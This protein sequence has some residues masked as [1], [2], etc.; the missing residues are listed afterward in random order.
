[1]TPRTR[2][3]LLLVKRGL[4]ETRAG[5]QAA[6]AAGQVTVDGKVAAKPAAPT[7]VDAIINAAP[8]HPYVSRGGIK[9][10]FALDQSAI[11]VSGRTCI[12]VGASTGGFTQVLLERGAARVYAVDV[13]HGQLH[14]SLRQQAKVIS[15]EGSDIRTIAAEL[16][17]PRPDLVTIDVSFIALEQVLPAVF[18]IVA[19]PCDIVALIKPQFELTRRDLKK[20]IVRDPQRQAAACNKV[21]AFLKAAGCEVISIFRS[22][23]TGSDGNV[24]FFVIARLP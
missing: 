21:V 12:D 4:F 15:L 11:V 14:P 23:I 3:D 8:A 22:P 16:F 6:I 2:L 7:N 5:A 1:M 24:E 18:A 17:D 19:R 10:S 9:L 20:G 13:G